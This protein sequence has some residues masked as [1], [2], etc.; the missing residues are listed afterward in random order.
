MN[1]IRVENNATM[2]GTVSNVNETTMT[3]ELEGVPGPGKYRV[4]LMN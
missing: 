3:F 4:V 1:L 2:G